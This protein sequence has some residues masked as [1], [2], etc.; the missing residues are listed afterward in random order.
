MGRNFFPLATLLNNVELLAKPLQIVP[1]GESGT[2]QFDAL[3]RAVYAVSL[4]I[5]V[6]ISVPPGGLVK[7][8]SRAAEEV[9]PLAQAIRFVEPPSRTHEGEAVCMDSP[10]EQMR[11]ERSVSAADNAFEIVLFSY[12]GVSCSSQKHRARVQ[13]SGFPVFQSCRGLDEA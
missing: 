11:F 13:G 3:R 9:D 8:E 4:P 7:C 10:L 6:V 1:F 5:R 2:A 12:C